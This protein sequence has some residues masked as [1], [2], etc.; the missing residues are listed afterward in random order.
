MGRLVDGKWINGD[1]ITSDSS[2]AYKRI[3]RSFRGTISDD[4]PIFKPESGRYH[5][6]VSFACPWAHRT[7]IYRSL[8]G[9]TDHI[10]VSVVHPEMLDSGW[11]FKKDFD[12]ATGDD[13]YGLDYL[14]QLY[15]K[16]QSDISTSVTVPVLWDKK[17]ETIVN[18]ESSEII[19]IFNSSFN[20]L[21]GN[22][23]DYCP[24]HL[25]SQI[26]SL[27]ELIYEKLNNGVYLSGFAKS[28]TAYNNAVDGAFDVLDELEGRLENKRYLLGDILTEADIRLIPTL[29]RF[30][31][32]YFI[33]FKC[34]K[35]RISDYKNLFRYVNDLYQIEAIKNTTDFYHIKQHYYYSHEGLNPHRIVP[36]TRVWSDEI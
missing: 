21:T 31:L 23:D 29:L 11:S 20:Q 6:Y 18:N 13:L 19:R 30:D 33:H 25:L 2:G 1:I 36:K 15:Q 35:K 12:G 26:D 17:A 7:L 9:L 27:N 14:Y 28:Q 34:S 3:P 24:D 10:S 32:V 16:A 5:L 22:D 8:K 4:D